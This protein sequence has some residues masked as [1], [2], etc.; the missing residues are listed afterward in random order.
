[1]FDLGW[2]VSISVNG[3]QVPLG[4]S[5]QRDDN[6]SDADASNDET[7]NDDDSD[8]DDESVVRKFHEATLNQ[9][10]GDRN[11]NQQNDEG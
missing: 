5:I 6:G 7:D 1:M 3:F 4:F 10:P 2:I 8:D 9:R 11:E